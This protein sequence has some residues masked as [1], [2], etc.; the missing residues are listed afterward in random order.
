MVGTNARSGSQVGSSAPTQPWDTREAGNPPA[1]PQERGADRADELLLR[2]ASSPQVPNCR[3]GKQSS[4]LAPAG[5]LDVSLDVESAGL[6]S[7]ATGQTVPVTE[8][9]ILHVE[10][11]KLLGN[12]QH[13]T[14]E[15]TELF[16]LKP[17]R[18]LSSSHC[19]SQNRKVV[20]AGP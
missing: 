6:G 20:V 11:F 9:S 19:S 4:V 13:W 16:T 17:L 7:K 2:G 10:Q 1:P 8:N 18:G 14:F 12:N 5:S 15:M 3:R